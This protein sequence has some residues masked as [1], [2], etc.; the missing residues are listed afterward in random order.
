MSE[1]A[2]RLLAL[3]EVQQLKI[4]HRNNL[5]NEFKCYANFDLH[6]A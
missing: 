4:G 3:K 5:A 1:L 2:A 6:Q